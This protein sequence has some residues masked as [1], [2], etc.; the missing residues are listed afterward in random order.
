MNYRGLIPADRERFYRTLSIAP[1]MK[2]YVN[3]ELVFENLIPW[4]ASDSIEIHWNDR[5]GIVRCN[6]LGARSYFPPIAANETAFA[7][8][9][10]AV[11][12]EESAPLFVGLTEPMLPMFPKIGIVLIDDILAE[13]VYSTKEL[14]ELKGGKF[15]RRRNLFSQFAKTYDHRVVAYDP[16]HRDAVVDLLSRYLAQGGDEADYQP[17]LTAL[18]HSGELPIDGLLLF[19]G[20]VLCALSVS[21]ISPYGKGVVLFEK[22]D[23]ET[24]GA[25][26]AIAKYAA[27]GPLAS[28]AEISRQED[29]GLPHLRKAKL[30]NQ[31][32]RKEPKYAWLADPTMAG[33]HALYTECFP[34]D[35]RPYVDYVFL[36]QAFRE[37]AQALEIDGVVAA[38]LL[39]L[40]RRIRFQQR[41]WTC[42]T[43]V[44]A[45]V[46][47]QHRGKGLLKDV[48]AKALAAASRREIPFVTLSPVQE[49]MYRS[50][51]FVTYALVQ[52][53]GNAFPEVAVEL[54][55]TVNVATLM[56][57]FAIATA[58]QSLWHVRDEARW[59][60]WMNALWQ[61][62]TIVS[63][64]KRNG[65]PI[66][67]VAHRGYEIEE[68]L[69]IEDINPIVPGFDF[70]KALI[71][72]A[73]GTPMH[74][75]RIAHLASFWSN[76]GVDPSLEE[77]VAVRF[78]DPVIAE[79]NRT[80]EL[81][82]KNGR[83][84]ARESSR[85]DFVL[86]VEELAEIAFL[87][88]PH[89]ALSRWFATVSCLTYD[90]Y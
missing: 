66:G 59:Y 27:M 43:I 6:R 68:L 34:E 67:Y 7:A 90:R 80:Y 76:L 63:L 1:W 19:V 75:I 62:Q 88:K 85:E 21:S 11:L 20:D 83:I 49:A 23:V 40:P 44:G 25:Y 60:D 14:A 10:A 48:L 50:S 5:F 64:I 79:N 45:A 70:A 46:L 18:D 15:H 52:P 47:P 26:T 31:P 22:A 24:I 53:L 17:L 69:L 9:I 77:T 65:A 30:A 78:V 87:G 56:R 54:E 8:A 38:G 84:E 71:P 81:I 29:L 36:N 61:D 73:S 3:S 28:V 33:L 35:S 4:T 55:A 13:Y 51:G 82:A 32:L 86:T 16:S 42:E 39:A 74:M 41:D 57:L 12:E 58:G 72:A 89:P 37:R 2:D